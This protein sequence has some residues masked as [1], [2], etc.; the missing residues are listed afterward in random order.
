VLDEM[1]GLSRQRYVP[2]EFIAIVYEG[3]GRRESALQWFEKAYSERSIHSFI[4]PDPRLDR[5]RAEPRFRDL[6]RR[7]GLPQ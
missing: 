7:M 1:R 2:P 6:M 4:L 3:L 5:I